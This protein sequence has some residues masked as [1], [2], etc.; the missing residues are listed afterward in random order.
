M[1][2]P[3][4]L[5]IICGAIMFSGCDEVQT[6]QQQPIIIATSSPCLP[7]DKATVQNSA[8][9]DL[10]VAA[11]ALIDVTNESNA[12]DKAKER[13]F[14]TSSPED[15]QTKQSLEDKSRALD[16]EVRNRKDVLL[17]T[18]KRLAAASG[19]HVPQ[20]TYRW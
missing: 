14:C 13:L 4:A 20:S 7:P 3:M 19:K 15:C 10:L 18:V 8:E 2:R 9:R 1:R 11:Q 6:S 16:D 17:D 12:V 5:S